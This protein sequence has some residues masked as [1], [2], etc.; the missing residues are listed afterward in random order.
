MRRIEKYLHGAEVALVEPLSRQSQAIALQNA[1]ITWPQDR[2]RGA[3]ATP[4]VA[5]TPK[6]KFVLLDLSID[7][8]LGELSLV[9]GKLGSGKSLLLLSLL[10][11]A[12]IL[13]GQLTCP[14]SPPDAI[15]S[16]VDQVVPEEEWVVQ[17][18]CAY[19]PQVSLYGDNGVETTHIGDRAPGFATLRSEV[20]TTSALNDCEVRRG[21]QC[22]SDELLEAS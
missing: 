19:V 11:E 7:F 12:D 18:V 8:P 22:I 17:G 1:T 15:A 4:S 14:R 2:V 16:F 10:G 21:S 9:C 13:A 5:S 6:Q 20:C 3:S